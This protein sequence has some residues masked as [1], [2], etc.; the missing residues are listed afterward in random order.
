[1]LKKI[2]IKTVLPM[3]YRMCC[4]KR[5]KNKALFVE[6]RD[7]KLSSNCSRVMSAMKKRCGDDLKT[8]TVFLKLGHCN[9]FKYFMKCMKLMPVLASSKY[10]FLDESSNV[11][12]ALKLRKDTKLVQLW[13]GCGALKKFGI[14]VNCNGKYYGNE[15]MFLI[16]SDN[17]AWAYEEATGLPNEKLCAIGVPRTDIYFRQSYKDKCNELREKILAGR[18]KKIILFAPTFRGNIAKPKDSKGLNLDLMYKHLGQEYI[19]ISKFHDTLGPGR[20][21][22]RHRDF[23]YDVTDEWSIEEAMGVC[24]ILISDFSSLIFEFSLLNKPALFYAYD[25]DDYSKYPGIYLDYKEEMPGVICES[26]FDIIKQIKNGYF[27]VSKMKDFK[28]KYMNACDGQSTK[29]L[30]SLLLGE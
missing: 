7:K 29:R 13:H 1:M 2:L 4:I 9:K 30:L 23:Y 22:S 21:S 15:D 25:Y 17:I 11:I 6:V 19:V 26:T 12:A 14:S 5:V 10:V 24:D 20:F 18:N 16:S 3:W 8:K 27:D 28:D